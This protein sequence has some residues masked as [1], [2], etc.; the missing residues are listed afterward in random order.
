MKRIFSVIVENEAGVLSRIANLFS[1]R[2]YNIE[3][4]NVAPINELNLS[5]MTIVTEG[6]EN[7]LEQIGK[8][9]NKLIDT[10]KVI[11]YSDDVPYV[12]REMALIKMHTDSST[13]A[14]ILRIVDIFRGKIVDVSQNSYTI[15]VTG[16]SEKINAILNL[17]EPLG[18]KEIARTGK[19]AMSRESK[20]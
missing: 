18:I 5:R 11:E 1:A 4:L 8:Q 9:L 13:R 3:S 20:Q 17:L 12:E 6:D 7:I 10:I 14:E 16:S 15:E 19:V 2:G